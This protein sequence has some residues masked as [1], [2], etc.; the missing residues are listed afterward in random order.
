MSDPLRVLFAYRSGDVDTKGGA[1]TVMHR[2][3]EAL[4]RL[5]AGVEISYDIDPDPTGFDVVH[6]V[7]VWSPDTAIAQLRNLRERGATVVWQPFYLGYSEQAWARLGVFAAFD[8]ARPPAE[9][10][11]LLAAFTSG[12]LEVNGVRR[13]A[14]N[15]PVP[16]FYPA[17]KEML[18]LVDR[19]AVC[20]LH[21][22]Q[23]ISNDVGLRGTPFT[24][25]PHGVEAER[26]AGAPPEAFREHAGLGSEPFALCVGAI[27]PRK[28]QAMLAHALRDT[29]V[30]LVLLGPAL[31][32]PY[33][34]RV[35]A[36]GGS[37]LIHIDRVS[38]ELVASAYAAAAVHVLPS[39]AEGAAL[40]NLEA[41]AA[42]C[43]LVVSDRSSEFEYFGELGRYCDPADP[44]SIRA[45]V[46]ESLD[47]RE[48]R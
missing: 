33:L 39:W 27:D 40:A 6:P 29:G 18:D 15:E 28:N 20:S 41:A 3:A 44:A 21:E 47:A 42:G 12:E 10:E 7:N 4:E 46:E 17:M 34:E 8:P 2:T 25:T 32:P 43:P 36:A 48:R 24:H 45:A 1:A 19:L 5:G 26:F 22:A 11:Q 31:E 13:F 14:R 35:H 30:P 23:L 37:N 38:P 9:R 16:G